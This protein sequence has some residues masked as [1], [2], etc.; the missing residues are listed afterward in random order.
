MAR[1]KKPSTM[2]HSDGAGKQQGRSQTHR[3]IHTLTVE[4]EGAGGK[5]GEGER[6]GVMDTPDCAEK[7]ALGVWVCFF[8]FPSPSTL[9]HA[10]P[11]INMRRQGMHAI[12]HARNRLPC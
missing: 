12:G 10:R 9:S 2:P 5:G 1:T 4:A 7:P 3:G 11:L 6:A 8:V